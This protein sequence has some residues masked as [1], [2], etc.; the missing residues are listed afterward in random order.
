MSAPAT[1]PGP[2][3][4]PAPPRAG[5]AG[6]RTTSG[7]TSQKRDGRPRSGAG[8]VLWHS[9]PVRLALGLVVLFSVVSLA[10]LGVAF[11][12][13]RGSIDEQLD[14]NLDQHVAGFRVTDDP[15]TLAT[16]VAAE[17]AAADPENRIFVFL[18]PGG[19]SVGNARVE[20][21]GADV[22]LSQRDGGRK[23][24][25]DGYVSR[26]VPMAQGILVVAESLEPLR[27]LKT[28]FL[29]LI[30]FSLIPTFLLSLSGGVGL[31]LASTRRVRRIE[32]T[33][34]RL[35]EGDLSARVGE[36]RRTDDLA[37]IGA[38]LD[39]MAT[40][41]ETATSALR[42]VSADIAH[43][44]KTPVQRI[45]VLLADLRDRLP[46]D[47]PEAGIAEKAATEAERAVAVFRSLL[48]IA[49]IEAGSPRA[50]FVPVDLVDLVRTFAEIYEPTAEDSGHTLVPAVT[51]DVP[52]MVLGDKG[53]LGQV[54][55]NLIENALR[56]TPPGTQIK[57][58]VAQ[59]GTQ[60]VLGITDDGPGIP[61]EAR[62]KV[63][64]R[65]YRLERSR[66]TPGNGLGLSL[67]AAIADLHGATLTL[68]SVLAPD[69]AAPGLEIRLAFD[70]APES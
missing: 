13:I 28:T 8:A 22:V 50:R 38:G 41:Q 60:V 53:L 24:G 4:P 55:A 45:A 10:T 29:R 40:A 7:Q 9:T 18:A 66:T 68:D 35:T 26:A 23:L 65:L 67:V 46:E 19:A 70:A 48:Q 11:V 51:P 17:A 5:G 20:L 43:D 64:R 47:G 32:T 14:A 25:R 33:L 52:L 16:L 62:D 2:K 27:D 56:H 3:A 6:F 15:Q 59:E 54:I 42:Q 30:G 37:R 34:Q 49:Q 31:A 1:G 12:Q 21:R 69:D 61:E 58:T 57:L 36:E 44:L 63:L 39:R